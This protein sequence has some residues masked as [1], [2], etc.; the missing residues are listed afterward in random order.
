MQTFADRLH[1]FRERAGLTQQQL[2]A[3]S[4]INLWTIRG[5]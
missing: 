2:A 5:Y 3:A 4:D 1:Q